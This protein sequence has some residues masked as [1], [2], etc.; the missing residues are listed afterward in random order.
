M[1]MPQSSEN[2]LN[3]NCDYYNLQELLDHIKEHFPNTE[4]SELDISIREYCTTTDYSCSSDYRDYF[5]IKK[6]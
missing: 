4:F 1:N 3:I 6:H 2:E 5:R